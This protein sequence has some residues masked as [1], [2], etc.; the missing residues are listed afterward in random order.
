MFYELQFVEHQENE[1]IITLSIPLTTKTVAIELSDDLVDTS[2]NVMLCETN[3]HVKYILIFAI[4]S[5][6][7][8]NNLQ[9]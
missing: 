4:I 8:F 6:L 7:I 9:N 5:L 1:S 2:N 3:K